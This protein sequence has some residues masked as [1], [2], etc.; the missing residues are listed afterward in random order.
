[1]KMKL[2]I[3]FALSMLLAS[4]AFA[5]LNEA[6]QAFNQADYQ[7]AYP[8]MMALS[9]E[10]NSV[11]AYYMGLMYKGGLGVTADPTKAI[12]YFEASDKSFN[13][14][15]AMALGKMII[16]GEGTEK[17]VALGLQYLKKA[18]YAGSVDA[19]YELAQLYEEGKDVE[20]NLN[21]AF[22]FYYM[23]ALKGDEKAQLKTARYYLAGRGIVQDFVKAKKWYTRAANQ[24]YIPA[25]QEWADIL[26]S[27]PRYRNPLDAYSWY[28][29]LAAYNSDEI[30][31]MA[32]SRRDEIGATFPSDMLSVQQEKITNWRPVP[33]E[34]S[35][36]ISER[37]SAVLPV[38][39]GFNDEATIKSRLDSGDSLS[40][41]GSAYGINGKM[42]ETA[43]ETGD[44]TRLELAVDAAATN[45]QIKVYG[46]YGDL[47]RNRFSDPVSAVKW[48][49]KGADAGESYAQYQLGKSYCEGRGINPPNPSICYGWL[50]L[51]SKTTDRNLAL[52]I[53][54]A[55]RSVESLA[56]PEELK[57]GREFSKEQSKNEEPV[58][59]EQEK[60]TNLFNLF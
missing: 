36:P 32:A 39:A 34:A 12:R 48:Y 46:Y 37:Q 45:G 47:L 10:G 2:S 35:V 3:V 15:A 58:K 44:R 49:R 21:Y 25:Q 20:L 11:A 28:S 29:I 17:N 60:K 22:G 40:A 43:V 52:T 55:I 30:G 9:E 51:A 59:E 16:A 26:S 13:P 42:I 18:A 24:G 57:Q 41:D 38:I 56:T 19:L 23:G 50:L 1:M 4:Q 33:A 7:T 6:V 5:G 31:K 27:H 53:Q 54:E 8:E 14:D